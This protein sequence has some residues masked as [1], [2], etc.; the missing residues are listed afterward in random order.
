VAAHDADATWAIA[1]EAAPYQR[2]AGL[3]P[4][5]F[6]ESGK[7]RDPVGEGAT[8]VERLRRE[9][10][11]AVV[12][13]VALPSL[14]WLS[15]KGRRHAAA[16][17]VAPSDHKLAF[18][19][20]ARAGGCLTL[21]YTPSRPDV[22]RGEEILFSALD[23]SGD[24]VLL[25]PSRVLQ[26]HG[27]YV[28]AVPVAAVTGLRSKSE[29]APD[30]LVR[31]ESGRELSW[32]MPV[33]LEQ[34][35]PRVKLLAVAAPDIVR[36]IFDQVVAGVDTGA[37]ARRLR[38]D[39]AFAISW[40]RNDVRTVVSSAAVERGSSPAGIID[41]S[42]W[43]HAQLALERERTNRGLARER[44]LPRWPVLIV[45]AVL[46]GIGAAIYAGVHDWLTPRGST[47]SKPFWLS[48]QGTIG[49]GW[50]VTVDRMGFWSSAPAPQLVVGVS[51]TNER[52]RPQ[53]L[54]GVMTRLRIRDSSLHPARQCY[55]KTGLLT[56]DLVVSPSI[57]TRGAVCFDV[58][59]H[60]PASL[61]LVVE[62]RPGTRDRAV[63]FGLV[64]APVDNSGDAG[65]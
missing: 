51:L 1:D 2:T 36:T 44:V 49:G 33:A 10:I 7:G 28:R 12:E 58:V 61:R 45:V 3:V 52:A 43:R 13:Q 16:L 4:V 62:P 50:D 57:S 59:V 41:D 47:P 48:Q 55:G 60:H 31:E 17:L 39:R 24:G 65:D 26:L 30:L 35:E 20:L 14:P 27:E 37:I 56:G 42:T 46:A 19:L 38:R 29:S 32:T 15:R 25:T 18:E 11:D 40:M 64:D 8:C 22:V 63:W 23:K 34:G 5:A 54:G 21:A 53:T 6:F 9:D